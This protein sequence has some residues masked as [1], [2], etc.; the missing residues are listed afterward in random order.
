MKNPSPSGPVPWNFARFKVGDEFVW[1]AT[2]TAEDVERFHGLSGD[3][4]PLHLDAE[5]AKG[6]G[7]KDRVAYGGLAMAYLSRVIGAEFPGHGTV[8]LSQNLKFESP[9]YI[10][11][12]IAV[13]IAVKQKNEGLRALAL[14]VEI[15]KQGKTK[16]V[17][18]EALVAAAGPDRASE[19]RAAASGEALVTIPAR[20]HAPRTAET[21]AVVTGASRGIGAAV[22][23]ALAARGLRVVV[24][25]NASADAAQ[26]LVQRVRQA[27]GAAAA[28]RADVFA[29]EGRRALF[30][31]AIREFGRVDILVNNAGPGPSK[32]DLADLTLEDLSGA[33][34]ACAGSSFELSR[35]AAPGM[36]ERGFGRIVNIL[37]SSVI[38]PPPVGWTAYV[39]AKAALIGLTRSL[40]VELAPHG[41]TCNMVSPSLVPTDLW[42]QL[43]EN[44]L[45][46]MALR[47]PTRRLAGARDV[48]E[49]VAFLVSPEAQHINGA[50]MPVTG[51]EAIL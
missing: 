34:L 35:L 15:V 50:H 23:E 49:T 42:S 7:Y 20:E 21:V 28:V 40:A 27:G 16:A 43:T 33:F 51:G 32:T 3:S 39:T 18:G 45:R 37:S 11:D 38:G 30:D 41:I 6:L 17:S 14:S 31:G 1:E 5:F 8:W 13:K 24:N 9:L 46:A 25:Y 4:N 48:A 29:P 44:Q 22:A 36:R 47:N 10:G 19:G 12:R 2:V 26:A